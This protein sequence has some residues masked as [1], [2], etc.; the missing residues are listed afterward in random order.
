[1]QLFLSLSNGPVV[2]AAGDCR[3]TLEDVCHVCTED[4]LDLFPDDET[5]RQL[6]PERRLLHCQVYTVMLPGILCL[7]TTGYF[8]QSDAWMLLTL[9][10]PCLLN[11]SKPVSS[12]G[13]PIPPSPGLTNFPTAISSLR[14]SRVPGYHS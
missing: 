6:I 8:S 9:L 7:I 11:A 1:M 14:P 12:R 3:D 5:S 2:L 4:S 10:I 13:G